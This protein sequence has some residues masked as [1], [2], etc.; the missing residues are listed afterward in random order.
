M[1]LELILWW[2]FIIGI[3]WQLWW[4]FYAPKETKE[5][6]RA[7]KKVADRAALNTAGKFVWWA[8]KK[9]R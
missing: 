4:W 5:R 7:A 6:I 3:G 2:L 9:A 8:I 1:K